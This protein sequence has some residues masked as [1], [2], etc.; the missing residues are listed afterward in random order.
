MLILLLYN[1]TNFHY[2]LNNIP[3]HLHF[4]AASFHGCSFCIPFCWHDTSIRIWLR[5]GHKDMS[6]D[7]PLHM[8]DTSSKVSPVGRVIFKTFFT[9]VIFI[10]FIPPFY[11]WA[12]TQVAWYSGYGGFK[13][14]HLFIFSLAYVGNASGIQ[15]CMNSAILILMALHQ[16]VLYPIQTSLRC[17]HI[18]QIHHH[19]N[20]QHGHSCH[21]SDDRP[22]SF[23]YRLR[24]YHTSYS[25]LA[26]KYNSIS[27]AFFIHLIQSSENLIYSPHS[28][29]ISYFPAPL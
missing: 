2:L 1:H 9:Q 23:S 19:Y 24:N 27:S 14:G 21:K 12:V 4:H 18:N 17:F 6:Y 10:I 20:L 15:A 13:L 22:S 26:F 3:Y 16:W 29:L 5:H 8:M 28:W 25:S 7:Y 11:H